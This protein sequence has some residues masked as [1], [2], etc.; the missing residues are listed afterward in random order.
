MYKLVWTPTQLQFFYDNE[1]IG[2]VDAGSGFWN[3]GNF[4]SSGLPNPWTQG[5]IM[6]PFDQEF[7]IIM[8]LAVG[9]TAYFDDSFV[10]RNNPKPWWNNSPRASADFWEGRG[11]WDPT[12]ERAHTDFS[13][14]KVDYVRVWAL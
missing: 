2:T 13:H 11:G 10:N 4:A 8:N 12:W 7:Y 1:H 14:M 6:A 3:R 5:T 9:G